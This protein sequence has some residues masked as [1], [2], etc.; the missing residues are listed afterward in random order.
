[1][2][3]IE[4][5]R[6][7]LMSIILL[8]FNNSKYIEPCL[9]HIFAQTFKDFEVIAVDNASADESVTLFKKYPITVIENDKNLGGC[10]GINT[11]IKR[12]QGQY[13]ML[14]DIDT[15]IRENALEKFVAY[16]ETHPATG[17]VMGKLML[18]NTGIIN[19]AGCTMNLLGHNWCVGLNEKDENQY[20]SRYINSV[21]GAS[22]FARRKALEVVGLYDPDMFLYN[23]DVDLSL[24]FLLYGYKLAFIE[25]AVIE[26]QYSVSV[27]TPTKYSYLER[28]RL[29]LLLKNFE[30]KTLILFAP[31]FVFQEIGIL[32]YASCSGLLLKKLAGYIWFVQ[33]IPNT[34][35][36]RSLIQRERRL[37]DKDILP[38]LETFFG[39]SELQNF[40]V[41]NILNPIM[42]SYASI[43]FFLTRTG[44]RI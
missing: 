40:L 18:G 42:K 13:I 21:C 15:R 27:D 19:A 3:A 28:N 7:P 10:I 23:E 37:K 11:G 5:K 9:D 2:T 4:K 44:E 12:A 31:L 38:Q 39:Y 36:K 8:S 43:V 22:F 24:R 20:K 41:R 32:L 14:L 1:M 25:D 30:L 17:A 16:M 29:I 6:D 26:H 35:A 33:Q 34:L